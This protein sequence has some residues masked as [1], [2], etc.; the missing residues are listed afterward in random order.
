MTVEAQRKFTSLLGWRNLPTWSESVTMPIK[1]SMLPYLD[2][3]SPESQITGA[4]NT[5]VKVP[6]RKGYK[7]V[8]QNTDSTFMDQ[9]KKHLAYR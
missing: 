1:V 6:T 8:G 2:E 3:I 9:P 4:C 5:I 7:L